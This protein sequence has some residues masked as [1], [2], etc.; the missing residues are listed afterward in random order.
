MIFCSN[1]AHQKKLFNHSD[2]C[3]HTFHT[4]SLNEE[5]RL[6]FEMAGNI[7]E[8]AQMKIHHKKVLHWRKIFMF[9]IADVK[10]IVADANC[11]FQLSRRYFFTDV[12]NCELER[13]HSTKIHMF[14]YADTFFEPTSITTISV[15]TLHLRKRVPRFGSSKS[16]LSK[17]AVTMDIMDYISAS[18][19]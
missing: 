3:W 1:N 5:D 8:K 18:A 17:E 11:T 13:L 4:Q 7:F 19:I 15:S 2:S 12:K 6:S 14:S 10:S 16:N 9:K